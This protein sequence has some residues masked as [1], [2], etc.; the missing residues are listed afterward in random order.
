MSEGQGQGPRGWCLLCSAWKGGHTQAAGASHFLLLPQA[1]SPQRKPLRTEPGD[2]GGEKGG[3]LSSPRLSLAGDWIPSFRKLVPV[4]P[5][6]VA[7]RYEIAP[8]A[9]E[10]GPNCSN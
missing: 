7:Q 8:A 5:S 9:E 2:W 1:V 6:S 10:K 3:L 4:P